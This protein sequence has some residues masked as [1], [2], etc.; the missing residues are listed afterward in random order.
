MS[1]SSLDSF[2]SETSA[3]DFF[4]E[5]NQRESF[6]DSVTVDFFSERSVRTAEEAGLALQPE[7]VPKRRPLPEIKPDIHVL[8]GHEGARKK[9]RDASKAVFAVCALAFLLGSLGIIT[10]YSEVYAKQ[11]RIR[12]LN[13]ELDA[14]RQETVML[15]ENPVQDVDMNEVYQYATDELGMVEASGEATSFIKVQDRSRTEVMDEAEK[16]ETRVTI[17]WFS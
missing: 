12:E 3:D 15:T 1:R 16:E 13:Q 9:K 2:F 5:R 4:A 8:P 14:I 11:A 7:T 6:L 10:S 17:H